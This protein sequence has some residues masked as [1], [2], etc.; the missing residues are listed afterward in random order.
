MS[1]DKNSV[2][3]GMRYLNQ[4]KT[5]T[6][7]VSGYFSCVSH[8]PQADHKTLDTDFIFVKILIN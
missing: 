3:T 6:G 8:T 1:S 5:E 2:F 4:M 7:S